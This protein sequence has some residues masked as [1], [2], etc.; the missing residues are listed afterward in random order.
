M[1]SSNNTM[2]FSNS[3]IDEHFIHNMGTT[4]ETIYA[5]LCSFVALIIV[6]GNILLFHTVLTTPLLRTA[7]NSL[8]LSL[9][10]A[11]LVAGSVMIP[12]YVQQFVASSKTDNTTSR[13]LCLLRKFLFLLT[14]GAS[15]T[16]LAVV[17]VD[18]MFAVSRPFVYARTMSAKLVT[19]IIVTVWT[20]CL[21]LTS[22]AVFIPIRSWD[23]IIA[24]CS[25]GIPRSSYLVVTPVLFYV[26]GC[27]ILI[28]YIK[29]FSIARTHR[30]KITV[31]NEPSALQPPISAIEASNTRERNPSTGRERTL[32]LNSTSSK[33]SSTTR[34][35]RISR[36]RNTLS[37]DLKAAKTVSILVG[38]F[39]ACWM[40]V[41]SFY[42]YLNTTRA[43]I[44]LSKNY[45]YIHDAFMFLSFLNAAIDPVLYIFLNKDMKSS[46]KRNLRN[47]FKISSS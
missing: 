15:I 2:N 36:I 17:S 13:N 4:Y 42:I 23:S 9:A 26:P 25:P 31:Q 14:S 40:P 21:T 27:T 38:L 35:K 46:L 12:L 34:M 32:T 41:A 20:V 45:T 19:S 22:C 39:L 33:K 16:S 7:T 30:R 5:V 43:D 29:I 8:L 1:N 24:T 47:V 37:N 6:I 3:S 11:D 18:R 28:C 10:T 44:K